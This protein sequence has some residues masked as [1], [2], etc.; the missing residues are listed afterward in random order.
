MPYFRIIYLVYII[1]TVVPLYSQTPKLQFS[2]STVSVGNGPRSVVLIDLDRDGNRDLAVANIRG[3]T[4]SLIFGDGS[5]VFTLQDSISTIH[6][7][8]HAIA[9]GDFNEDGVLDVVTANRDSHTVGLFLG[10]GDGGFLPPTFFPTGNGP[11]WIGVADFNEDGHSD[12]AVTNRDDDNITVLLGDGKG[13]FMKTGDF[14]T[15]DG[16]VPVASA[17]IN[18]D[19]FIDLVVGNDLSDTLVVMVGDSLGNFALTSETLVGAGP[20]NIAIGDLNQ[21]GISDIAVAC[22]LDGT[23][24]VLYADGDGGFTTRSYSA[25]GGSF[26]VVIEDFDGDGK[27]D[28]AV[29]DGVNDN[30][31]FLLNEGSG[32]FAAAQTF[33]VGLA[34]H[35]IISGDFNGDGRPDIA[36]PNTGDNTITILINETPRQENVHEIAVLQQLYSDFFPDPII[37][38]ADQPLRLLVT[39]Q[40]REHVNRLSIIPYINATDIVR[41]GDITTV[42]FTPQNTGTI[43]IRNIGHGFTG[44][45]IIVNDAIAKDSK[46]LQLGRQGVSIIHSKD[47]SQI[48]PPSIRVLKGVPLTIYNMSLSGQQWVTIEPWVTAPP[49]NETGNVLPSIV[50]TFEFTPDETGSYVIQHIVNGYTGTLVVEDRLVTGIE[51]DQFNPRQ[52][53]LSQNYPN[54]FNPE[55]VI[56]YFIPITSLVSI[57]VYNLLGQEIRTLTNIIHIAGH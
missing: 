2:S 12:L 39:T 30:I 40:S 37:S 19:G 10:D 9:T 54:P 55:T 21:D 53:S 27:S 20:K 7:A 47:H 46:V 49:T 4:I 3:S 45:I 32:N 52:F 8:P 1:V 51:T 34:P 25:G 43:Q 23:V 35:A 50:T 11:R 57:T 44:D 31:T 48:F 28:L 36:V 14:Y 24:T 33:P 6:K 56:E 18:G 42:E 38:I 13:A 17:D 5:G 41:V 16:P 29:A 22:L 26:A 15:G